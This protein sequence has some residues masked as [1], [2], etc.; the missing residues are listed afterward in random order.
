MNNT[1]GGMIAVLILAVSSPA[2]A[3]TDEYFEAVEAPHGGQLRMTGPFHVELVAKE[4]ELTVYVT[5]HA[6][7]KISVDGGLAKATVETGQTRTQ[8]HLHPVG[9]N[10]LKGSGVF[11]LMPNTVVIVFMKLPNHD[12][13]S[14]RFIPLKPKAE[15]SVKSQEGTSATDG[16]EHHH[17]HHTPKH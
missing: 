2:L 1:I 5:D 12:A 13:H 8:V 9:D 14:A 3:H 11:S 4:G 6:D 17:H 15:P 7:T 16:T 10:M